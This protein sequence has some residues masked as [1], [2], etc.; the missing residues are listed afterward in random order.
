MVAALDQEQKTFVVQQLAMFRTPSQVCELVK[1]QFEVEIS[2]QLVHSYHPERRKDLAERWRILFAETRRQFL[3]TV[4]A[5]P[6]ANQAYRVQQLQDSL[7]RQLRQPRTNE[8]MVQNILEQA[9]KEVGGMFTNQRQITGANGK[10]LFD[11]VELARSLFKELVAPVEDGG[12]GMD[13]AD[14]IKFLIDRYKVPEA[15]IVSEASN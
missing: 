10:P 15:Q 14:A 8:A 1:E 5:I 11:T 7:D 6:I 3:E 4:S 12:E 13:S 9:A 2:R